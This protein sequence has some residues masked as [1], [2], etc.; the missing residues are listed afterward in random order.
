M[1][2]GTGATAAGNLTLAQSGSGNAFASLYLIRGLT[3]NT[4]TAVA[5]TA[6]GTTLATVPQ[7][8]GNGQVVLAGAL[9]MAGTV[10]YPS[11]T[12]PA[13]GWVPAPSAATP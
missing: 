6:T 4:V 9:S 2:V 12:T 1:W 7:S 3:A 13:T 8:A 10:T 5:A 11:A